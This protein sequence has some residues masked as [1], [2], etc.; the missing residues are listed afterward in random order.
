MVKIVTSYELQVT[1][2]TVRGPA[3]VIIQF[4]LLKKGSPSQ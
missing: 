2:Y 3:P 1:S 4:F